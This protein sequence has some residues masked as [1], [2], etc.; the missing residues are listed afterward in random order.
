MKKS[1]GKFTV[2]TFPLVIVIVV[3]AWS[4]CMVIYALTELAKVVFICG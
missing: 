3:I 1:S 4:L 2:N